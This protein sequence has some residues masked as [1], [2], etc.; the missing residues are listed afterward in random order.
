MTNEAGGASRILLSIT[1]MT[2]SGCANTVTR[3]LQR[4][5]GVTMAEVDL[6]SERARVQG[7]ARPLDLIAAAQAAGFGATVLESQD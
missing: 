3:V 1:G 7:T 4:V 2:C 6:Q 5:P